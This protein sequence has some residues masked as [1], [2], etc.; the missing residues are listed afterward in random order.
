MKY[1]L[2]ILLTCFGACPESLL[3]QED[4]AAAERE[5]PAI[6][7]GYLF[8]G[9]QP[10]KAVNNHYFPVMGANKKG[11]FVETLKGL[12]RVKYGQLGISLKPTMQ[13]TPYFARIEVID[14]VFE[15]RAQLRRDSALETALQADVEYAQAKMDQLN[16]IDPTERVQGQP[17][18]VS[19]EE[20]QADLAES[21]DSS[22]SLMQAIAGAGSQV[23][24]TV[25]LTIEVTPAVDIEDAYAAIVLYHDAF[26]KEGKPTGRSTILDIEKIGDL[27]G[28]IPNKVVIDLTTREQ[29]IQNLEFKFYLFSGEGQPIA[30]NASGTI[31]EISEK[32]KIQFEERL[33]ETSLR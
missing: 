22:R 21:S 10:H 33:K 8:K 32:V 19:N 29:L 14:A 24:D 20:F 5:S 4:G 18:G 13:V 11:L 28:A 7:W 9:I 25:F 27:S 15:N 12:K 26:D 31:Q 3:A 16:S 17:E 1:L 30:T 2:C 6:K 23:A